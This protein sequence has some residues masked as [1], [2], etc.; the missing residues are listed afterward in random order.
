MQKSDM[1][2][3]P[4]TKD[5]LTD[6]RRQEILTI[7]QREGRALVVDLA[8]RFST[9]AITIR[10][11]LEFLQARGLI[12][13]T[14]GG[15]LPVRSN[16]LTDPSLQDKEKLHQREKLRIA[17][18]AVRMVKE[19]QCVILDSGSTT[20]A[21]SRAL[22]DFRELTVITNAVN[23]AAEL[24]GTS[25]DVILTG[26]TLRK[27]SFSLVGPQAEDTLREI[28][29]DVLF[30]GVDGFD[31]KVGLTTPNVLEARVNRAMA[32]AARRVVAVCDSSKFGKRS[33][34]VIVPPDAIHEV[35]TD[36]HVSRDTVQELREA[37]IEVTLV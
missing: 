25:I 26:G 9:S 24:A 35:I 30:L 13:R 23:I 37:G 27:N 7:V 19:G 22:R 28:N 32:H 8:Q 3:S 20:T 10:K 4:A 29:A 17:S 34:A 18:A 36:K 14:H 33:L 5:W 15:A 16:N 21:I 6:E 11:D 2:A 1:G 31:A 12:Q